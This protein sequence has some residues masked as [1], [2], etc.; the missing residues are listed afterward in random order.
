MDLFRKD[1]TTSLG[2]VSGTKVLC[3]PLG[4]KPAQAKGV[5][6]AGCNSARGLQSPYISGSDVTTRSQMVEW[7]HFTANIC[8][9]TGL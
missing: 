1:P 7:G 2:Q 8:R 5:H 6:S 3:M 4:A 9:K